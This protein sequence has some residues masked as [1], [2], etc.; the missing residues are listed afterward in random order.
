MMTRRKEL[1]IFTT[2]RSLISELIVVSRCTD[3]DVDREISTAN[4]TL[5]SFSA[6]LMLG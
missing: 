3:L 4:N 2:L 1:C 5:F 6:V